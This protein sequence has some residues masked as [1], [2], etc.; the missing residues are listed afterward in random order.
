[1]D[2]FVKTCE[3]WCLSVSEQLI[4]LGYQ[5]GDVL[6]QHILAGRVVPW[7][8]DVKDRAGYVVSISLGL[9]ALFGENAD[10]ERDWLN[11]SRTKLEG[12]SPLGYMLEGHMSHLFSIAEMVKHERGL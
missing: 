9:G 10:A 12:K 8:H 3:R 7:T 1:M 4:L 6:G 5:P 11:F 2:S